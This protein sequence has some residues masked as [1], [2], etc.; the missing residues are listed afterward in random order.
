MS[1]FSFN[2]SYVCR[3]ISPPSCICPVKLSM[4]WVLGCSHFYCWI[5]R[6]IIYYY[7]YPTDWNLSPFVSTSSGNE[8]WHLRSPAYVCSDFWERGIDRERNK[9]S[10]L[11]DVLKKGGFTWQLMKWE[12]TEAVLC[13]IT[14]F[15][16]SLM[17]RQER[18]LT[19]LFLSPPSVSHPCLGLVLV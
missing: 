6:V 15:P 11:R 19:N 2:D 16:G 17:F 4:V 10:F 8:Q 12:W 5:A 7:R 13:A 9:G 18:D 14:A 3:T 1:L